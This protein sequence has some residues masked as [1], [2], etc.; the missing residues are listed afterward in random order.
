MTK[1]SSKA[2]RGKDLDTIAKKPLNE[3]GLDYEGAATGHGVGCGLCVHEKSVRVDQYA[4]TLL[5][6]GDIIAIEPGYYHK[7]AEKGRDIFG[8]R[9]EDNLIVR[10]CQ[11]GRIKL[12]N[13]T[14]APY[15]RKLIEP[16]LMFDE[17]L[18]YINEYHRQCF[19]KLA[20]LLL[21]AGDERAIA[22]LKT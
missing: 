11:D 20:P 16:Q 10:E 21:Q 19:E 9:V 18:E 22:Y 15:D 8:V 7:V 1:H 12:E 6:D 13:I 17:T 14:F 4:N 2:I 3:I 5:R